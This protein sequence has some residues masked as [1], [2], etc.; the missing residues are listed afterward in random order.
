MGVNVLLIT[1]VF[2]FALRGVVMLP[3]VFGTLNVYF[4][5]AITAKKKKAP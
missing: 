3:A 1:R 5:S 2:L 4:R